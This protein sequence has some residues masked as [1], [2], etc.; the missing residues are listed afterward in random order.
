[1]LFLSLYKRLL[2]CLKC[3]TFINLS[4][5]NAFTLSTIDLCIKP[6]QQYGQLKLVTMEM[7]KLYCSTLVYM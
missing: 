5:I 1:M 4:E 6:F 7:E 2:W 3:C